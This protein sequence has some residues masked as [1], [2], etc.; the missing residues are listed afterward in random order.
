M[1]LEVVKKYIYNNNNARLNLFIIFLF[2][3]LP[4]KMA[5]AGKLVSV[6]FEVFGRVQGNVKTAFY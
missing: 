4:H 1:T 5:S 6:E 3:L 2:H